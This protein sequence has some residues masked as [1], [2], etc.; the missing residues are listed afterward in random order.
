MDRA[1]NSMFEERHRY[2]K[3]CRGVFV[4][5]F[6]E[7][8]GCVWN[9][10]IQVLF[11]VGGKERIRCVPKKSPIVPRSPADRGRGKKRNQ[12]ER[13]LQWIFLGQDRLM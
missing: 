8:A 3:C 9:M 10:R 1:R 7:D 4:S 2:N 6:R 13:H 12:K 5:P 11:N